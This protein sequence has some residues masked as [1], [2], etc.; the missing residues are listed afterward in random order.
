MNYYEDYQAAK[1]KKS[2]LFRAKRASKSRGGKKCKSCGLYGCVCQM[3]LF[4]ILE[5]KEIKKEDWLSK[6][7]RINKKKRLK[8]KSYM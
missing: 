6:L 7:G 4:D 2:A 8:R 1:N 5:E 3:T